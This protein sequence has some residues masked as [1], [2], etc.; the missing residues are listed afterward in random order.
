[1]EEGE[2]GEAEE[3]GGKGKGKPE[4]GRSMSPFQP[5]EKR[6]RSGGKGIPVPAGNGVG[7][8]GSSPQWVTEADISCSASDAVAYSV[9]ITTTIDE[10]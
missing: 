4:L 5:V 7:E 2:E 1:M 10:R 6:R 9:H 8:V 3:E